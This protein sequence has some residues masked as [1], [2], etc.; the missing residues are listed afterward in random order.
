MTA[1]LPVLLCCRNVMKMRARAPVPSPVRVNNNLMDDSLEH[2]FG[3]SFVD[4]F[5]TILH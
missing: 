1:K 2:E 4:I 3:I 5:E